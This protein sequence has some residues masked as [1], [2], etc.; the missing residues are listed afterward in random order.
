[1]TAA[2]VSHVKQPLVRTQELDPDAQAPA[3]ED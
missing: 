1:M 2:V 3:I